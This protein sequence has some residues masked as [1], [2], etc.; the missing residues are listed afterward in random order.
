MGNPYLRYKLRILAQ[1]TLLTGVENDANEEEDAT[2]DS[3][4]LT[5]LFLAYGSKIWAKGKPSYEKKGIF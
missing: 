3:T 4:W 1:S 2:D 5:G